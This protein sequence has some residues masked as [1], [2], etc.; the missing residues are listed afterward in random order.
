MPILIVT[1][2]INLYAYMCACV[3]VCVCVCVCV[4]VP[5]PIHKCSVHSYLLEIGCKSVEILVIG[6]QSMALSSKHIIV[7]HSQQTEDHRN[8]DT[9]THT[10]SNNVS[11]IK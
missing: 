4:C 6:K 10:L 8:L 3:L 11:N 7:P 1:F 9:H 2:L 5:C